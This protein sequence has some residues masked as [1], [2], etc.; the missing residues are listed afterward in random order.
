MGR[1]TMENVNGEKVDACIVRYFKEK[2]NKYLVYHQDEI[3]AQG[4]LKLYIGKVS[5]LIENITDDKEWAHVRDL[6]KEILRQNNAGNLTAIEDLNEK[7]LKNIEL[8][9]AKPFKLSTAMV[10]LLGKNRKKFETE[11]D[12]EFDDFD[13]SDEF[14]DIEEK[15]DE[16][17]ELSSKDEDESEATFQTDFSLEQHF[18]DDE[19]DEENTEEND[20]EENE[21]EFSSDEDE[22]EANEE[23]PEDSEDEEE[24]TSMKPIEIATQK[25][26]SNYRELYNEANEEIEALKAEVEEYKKIIENVKGLINKED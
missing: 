22:V 17:S 20:E 21:E 11:E 13:T 23:E 18:N 4:Y 5:A 9:S 14:D 19:N 16:E 25:P 26:V 24:D 2:D 7:E 15:D 6:I 8:V 1:M 12:E 3:D 10:E